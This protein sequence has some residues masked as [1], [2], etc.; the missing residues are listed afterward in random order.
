MAAAMG[1][2]SGPAP[3]PWTAPAG[4]GLRV[5]ATDDFLNRVSIFDADGAF[6]SAWGQPGDAP[7]QLHGPAGLAFDADGAVVIADSM[8][9]RIQRFSADGEY[10]GRLRAARRR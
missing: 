3:S 7:G 10:L 1:S 6:R 2:S 5:F 8:N 9:H 4:N